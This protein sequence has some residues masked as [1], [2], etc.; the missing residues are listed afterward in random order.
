MGQKQKDIIILEGSKSAFS[1]GIIGFC[2][3]GLLML[4]YHMFFTDEIKDSFDTV[5]F[6]IMLLMLGVGSLCVT[7]VHFDLVKRKYKKEIAIG[8]IG[9][10]KWHHLPHIEYIS[11]FKQMTMSG[12]MRTDPTISYLY[13]V[14]VWY[15]GSKNFTVYRS[16]EMQPAYD[17]AYNIAIKL[18][19]DMLDATVKNN[20][21]WVR[22]DKE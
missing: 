8:C 10:G 7:N 1:F 16:V 3:T 15:D 11:V 4:A 18:D 19:V 6:G 17:M 5:V 22:L 2:F 20:S 12:G 21:V 9:I 14:N 13:D